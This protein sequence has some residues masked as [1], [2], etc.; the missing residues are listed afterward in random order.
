MRG[1]YLKKSKTK[2]QLC[3]L[4]EFNEQRRKLPL[5]DCSSCLLR[6]SFANT[7]SSSQCA[8]SWSYN[9]IVAVDA[10]CEAGPRWSVTT[11]DPDRLW[12][13]LL[14]SGPAVGV[15]LD[16]RAH[17]LGDRVLGPGFLSRLPR[18]S[19][20]PPL[21]SHPFACSSTSA[22]PLPLPSLSWLA[23]PLGGTLPGDGKLRCWSPHACVAVAVV[24]AVVAGVAAV[25]VAVVAVAAAVVVAVVAVAAAVVVAVAGAAAVVMAA[26]VVP[27]S[28]SSR[29][30]PL[31][32]LLLSRALPLLLLLRR[33]RCR[34]YRCCCRGRCRCCCC[35]AAAIGD[36]AS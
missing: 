1:L 22:C 21:L 30:L 12:G 2:R 20:P 10:A 33:G 8:I 25:V 34:C 35:R 32:L 13:C 36:E 18:G 27:L 9:I 7:T 24:I 28:L 3:Q 16:F 23:V 29:A 17:P 4:R 14:G 5:T 15:A 11:I 31:L 26:A 6:R 19:S